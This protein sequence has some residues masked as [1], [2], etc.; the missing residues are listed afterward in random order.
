MSSSSQYMMP[1]RHDHDEALVMLDA[2]YLF[3]VEVRENRFMS[4]SNG[5]LAVLEN[6]LKN[7]QKISVLN[8]VK[9]AGHVCYEPE[10]D[11]WGMSLCRAA[12][13]L[14]AAMEVQLSSVL[15]EH[16]DIHLKTL[17]GKDRQMHLGEAGMPNPTVLDMFGATVIGT[18]PKQQP[19]DERPSASLE[20]EYL[21]LEPGL[22][23]EPSR[24]SGLEHTFNKRPFPLMMSLIVTTKKLIA[25]IEG[26]VD[27]VWIDSG[28]A[29]KSHEFPFDTKVLHD[30]V[31]DIEDNNLIEKRYAMLEI[32][33]NA[34]S[35]QESVEERHVQDV[36]VHAGEPPM[37]SRPVVDGQRYHDDKLEASP[38]RREDLQKNIRLTV[39][40]MQASSSCIDNGAANDI[41]PAVVHTIMSEFMKMNMTIMKTNQMNTETNMKTN[42]LCTET[43]SKVA[44]LSPQMIAITM[45]EVK[46]SLQKEIRASTQ[47]V[48]NEVKTSLQEEI[49]ASTQTVMK[50]VKDQRRI[51]DENHETL[52][53][54]QR[55]AVGQYD[56]ILRNVDEV[57]RK[58]D[59]VSRKNV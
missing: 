36:S 26:R 3:A 20:R 32:L 58:V 1:R 38:M 55:G 44:M 57:S 41:G 14:L 48:M 15:S 29:E 49:R 6:S 50:K 21:I 40:E 10:K 8:L 5:H 31:R 25:A 54:W 46:T 17:T 56:E 39:Q 43:Q 42:Q 33:S 4:G 18:I 7:N 51:I 27:D 34:T 19:G 47:T 28:L 45:N 16:P 53:A 30:F 37:A 2:E 12:C 59:A 11:D 9:L 23:W 22:R 35:P 13:H 24:M 52:Q